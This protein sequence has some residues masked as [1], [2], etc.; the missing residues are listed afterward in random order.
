MLIKLQRDLI[1]KFRWGS[2]AYDDKLRWN[3]RGCVNVE[4]KQAQE[5]FS[6]EAHPH[7]G[8]F[9]ERSILTAALKKSR[10]HAE[11][12]AMNRFSSGSVYL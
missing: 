3:P 11:Q 2:G 1:T 10:L 5:I 12:V 9:D 4:C 7:S 6:H 8:H